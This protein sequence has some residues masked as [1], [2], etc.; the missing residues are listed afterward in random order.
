[1]QF[2]KHTRIGRQKASPEERA[3]FRKFRAD[4]AEKPGKIFIRLPHKSVSSGT[5]TAAETAEN[6]YERKS[7]MKL[8]NIGD[9][10]DFKKAIHRCKDSVWLESPRGDKFDLK[11]MFS[12]YLAIG[13][14]VS[15][16][17]N[18]L[19]LFASNPEDEEILLGFF[20]HH[21]ETI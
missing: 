20:Q 10:E 14:L 16:C 18:D 13:K 7:V 6:D 2:R 19:E 4:S 15:E 5:G 9:I 1:M 17:G 8:N 3:A 11:S 12:Q 21:Q